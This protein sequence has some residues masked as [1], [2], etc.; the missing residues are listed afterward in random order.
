MTTQDNGKPR[1]LV[2]AAAGTTGTAVTRQLLDKGYPVTAL[3]RR[4]DTRSAALAKAGATIVIGDLIET[5]DLRQ[6]MQGVQRA[7]FVAPWTP[8]QLHG[9]MNFAVAAA[10]A[11]LETVVAITQWLAQPNHPSVA[12]RQ[13]YMT[14]RIF[15]WMPGVDT[16]AVNTGWFADNYMGVLPMAAQL[17]IFPFRLGDAKVAPVSSEDI[18]RVAVGALINPAPHVGR[19]YRPT[20]PEL[21]GPDQLA[22]TFAKVFGRPVQYQELSERMFF[23]AVKSAGLTVGPHHMAQLRH[24]IEDYRRGSFSA[25]AVTDTV[26]EVGGAEPEDFETIVRRHADANPMSQ[27][28]LAN[29][30]RAVAGFI[31]I[32]LTPAPDLSA[33]DTA[34]HQPLLRAPEYGI[35]NAAWRETHDVT[36]AFGT[37][38]AHESGH[39]R[40]PSREPRSSTSRTEPNTAVAT[41]FVNQ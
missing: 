31:K 39:I 18:A 8:T 23:K 11:K 32:L 19:Y 38:R 21:L 36:G 37:T 28:S 7:Y 33:Y 41:P 20:G 40:V 34:Q 10:D 14:D 4:E 6:A 22:A 13:S 3:V 9:A 1:I 26:R 24:Y 5:D 17:G 16:V 29:K 2:T 27:P 25:G 15:E 12:T 35:N 30:V